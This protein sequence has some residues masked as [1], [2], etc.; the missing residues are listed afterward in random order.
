MSC[1]S[2]KI[3]RFLVWSFPRD[4]NSLNS[5]ESVFSGVKKLGTQSKKS[6]KALSILGLLFTQV[7]EHFH[8]NHINVKTFSEVAPNENAH[9]SSSCGQLKMHR[10]VNDVMRIT[11]VV[12]RLCIHAKSNMASLLSMRTFTQFSILKHF[13]VLLWPVESGM[14]MVVWIRIE[15]CV[16][17]VS[18]NGAK[19]KGISV[20]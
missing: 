6:V 20:Y 1:Y 5:K 19:W 13:S 15:Q 3:S 7:A 16:F 10:N 17:G 18:E 12:P 2:K 8:W 11:W 4:T 9:V 14:K